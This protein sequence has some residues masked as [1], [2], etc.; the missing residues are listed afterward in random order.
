[1][2]LLVVQ[3]T[4]ETARCE[5]ASIT[6][7][8][9]HVGAR[10]AGEASCC[11]VVLFPHPGICKASQRVTQLYRNENSRAVKVE[12]NQESDCYSNWTST[13]CRS[14][15]IRRLQQHCSLSGITDN[16]Q[17]TVTVPCEYTSHHLTST[18]CSTH[19][20]NVN[21]VTLR[22]E[23]SLQDVPQQRS[24][25]KIGLHQKVQL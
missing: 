5:S 18:L 14:S 6:V 17:Y 23:L 8:H 21:S 19:T 24:Y 12:S 13:G 15:W 11:T 25:W 3:H 10:P 2:T 1:M 16:N 7:S 4:L 22:S 9:A 20:P